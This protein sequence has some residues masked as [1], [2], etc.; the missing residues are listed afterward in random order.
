MNISD[1]KVAYKRGE[2]ITKLLIN[3]GIN[4]QDSIEIAYDLQAGSYSEFALNHPE[5]I[6]PVHDEMGK[7]LR[8]YVRESHTILDCGTGEMTTLAG[9]TR[10]LPQRIELLAFDISLSRIRAGREYTART[11]GVQALAIR[12]FVAAMD[13]I[14][15]EDDSVDLVVT[16][17]ALEPNH[18]REELLL[19]ELFRVCRG[20]IILFEPSWEHNT[21]AGRLR[22]DQ[23]GYIRALP[24]HIRRMGGDLISESPI[25]HTVNPLN[26]TY[27]YVIDPRK[28]HRALREG[29][30]PF[31]CPVTGET[32]LKRGSYYWSPEGSYAYPIIEGVPILRSS[33]AILMTR[34]T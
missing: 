10:N 11:M 5:K 4:S 12:S 6:S 9:L 24:D 3:G 34:P 33:A 28:P 31:C 23:L 2:N 26:P 20:T 29:E 17:H 32:L 15:L 16:S 7:I 1:L 22:M 18:G 8:E 19:K 21:E 30:T 25:N 27:C 14:A 13:R